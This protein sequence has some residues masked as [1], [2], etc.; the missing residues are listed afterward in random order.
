MD[1]AVPGSPTSSSARCPARVTT[2]R[3][4]RETSP[5]NLRLTCSRGEPQTKATTAWGVSLQPGGRGP[6]SWAR[7]SSSLA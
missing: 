4:T 5:T 3:S 2:Q 7:R 6:V 1:L